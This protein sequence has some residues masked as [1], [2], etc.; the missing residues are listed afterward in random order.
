M[1]IFRCLLLA[2]VLTITIIQSWSFDFNVLHGERLKFAASSEVI[3]KEKTRH[4][5]ELAT[6]SKLS[7]GNFNDEI[8][9]FLLSVSII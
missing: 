8:N 5:S 4:E 3:Y 6:T 2:I 7:R 1:E 9:N